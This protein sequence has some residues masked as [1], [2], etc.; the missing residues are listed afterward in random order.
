MTNVPFDQTEDFS[1]VETQ[2]TYQT[3]K[4]AGWSDEDILQVFRAKARDNARTP[5][6]WNS[7]HNAGFTTGTP[8]YRLNPNYTGINVEQ[9]LSDPDSV[10]YYYQALIRLRKENQTLIYGSYQLLNPEDRNV[11]AYTRTGSGSKLLI[12]CNFYG[13][14]AEFVWHGRGKVL[15]SNYPQKTVQTL[16]CVKL[17]PYEAVIYELNQN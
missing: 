10:F 3:L 5:M 13:T 16:D 11:Y 9:A 12:V 15:L 4:E 1:D 17:R 2:G 8:W 6:Q 14:P 7:G